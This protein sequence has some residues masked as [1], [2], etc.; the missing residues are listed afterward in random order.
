MA[1]QA[2]AKR[3]GAPP[4]IPF[5]PRVFFDLIS[6]FYFSFSPLLS[7]IFSCL[8]WVIDANLIL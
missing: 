1:G 7:L 6:S 5:F 2:L 3:E 8:F 4:F